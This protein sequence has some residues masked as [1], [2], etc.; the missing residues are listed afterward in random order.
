M[1]PAYTK[2]RLMMRRNRKMKQMR[3][4]SSIYRVSLACRHKLM[5]LRPAQACYLR[6]G[7]AG[8]PTNMRATPKIAIPFSSPLVAAQ[9]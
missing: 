2:R 7:F 3:L 9:D 8:L 5:Y 4:N 6:M 1:A